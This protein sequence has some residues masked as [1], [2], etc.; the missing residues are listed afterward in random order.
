MCF[1][2]TSIKQNFFKICFTAILSSLQPVAVSRQ[3]PDSRKNT[4]AEITR[5]ALSRG[6]WPQ[7]INKCTSNFSSVMY[8]YSLFTVHHNSTSDQLDRI[9][10]MKMKSALRNTTGLRRQN[11]VSRRVLLWQMDPLNPASNNCCCK[12][13][14]SWV[15]V[16][17]FQVLTCCPQCS[18]WIALLCVDQYSEA[19]PYSCAHT[20]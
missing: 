9:L 8:S 20:R 14:C 11:L 4:V 19:R 5:R 3:D 17:P 15:S 7:V 12:C 13:Q 10:K 1:L 2:S 18:R 16:F 6:Q